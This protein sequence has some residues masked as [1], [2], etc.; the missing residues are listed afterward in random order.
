MS[1]Y[2]LLIKEIKSSIRNSLRRF[3]V[4]RGWFILR[5][6]TKLPPTVEQYLHMLAGQ[7]LRLETAYCFDSDLGIQTK[8]LG[9]FAE[10]KVEFASYPSPGAASLHAPNPLCPRKDSE[11]FLVEI[12]AES[13]EFEALVTVMP[14]IEQAQ[15]ILIRA[16]LG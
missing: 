14:W 1:Y 16:T 11:S 4:H 5:T 9:C 6:P 12:D 8:I 7:G 2:W 15:V 10:G 13:F 3:L